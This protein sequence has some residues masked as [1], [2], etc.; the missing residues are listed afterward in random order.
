M[1]CTFNPHSLFRVPDWIVRVALEL[2][3]GGGRDHQKELVVAHGQ[4]LGDGVVAWGENESEG[5]LGP[6]LILEI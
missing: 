4:E 3:P 6:S 2:T 1:F 5:T